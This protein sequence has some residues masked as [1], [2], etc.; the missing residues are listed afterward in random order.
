MSE[1]INIVNLLIYDEQK[2]EA[3]Q[4]AREEAERA[5]RERQ[6]KA[7]KDELERQER[8]KVLTRLVHVDRSPNIRVSLSNVSVITGL[9]NGYEMNYNYQLEYR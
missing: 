8:K 4:K 3:E 9:Y 2:E 7:K 6:E 1:L 5:E